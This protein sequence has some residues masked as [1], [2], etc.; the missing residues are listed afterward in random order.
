MNQ[1]F[2]IWALPRIGRLDPHTAFSRT[3]QEKILERQ[4][5]IETWEPG[6]PQRVKQLQQRCQANRAA[7]LP[8]VEHQFARNGWIVHTLHSAEQLDLL[9]Q[10]SVQQDI[11]WIDPSLKVGRNS[12]VLGPL[13]LQRTLPPNFRAKRRWVITQAAAVL[14]NS[15]SLVFTDPDGT[16]AALSTQRH[17][18]FVLAVPKQLVPDLR[19]AFAMIRLEH[20]LLYG[21]ALPP[22]CFILSSEYPM[23]ATEVPTNHLVFLDE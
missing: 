8:L 1:A 16:L 19:D 6:L 14:A 13:L 2:W 23:P 18:M 15:G 10:N 17:G 3:L 9:L 7:L 21:K 11:A 12:A 5:Q 22:S 4:Q 20:Y